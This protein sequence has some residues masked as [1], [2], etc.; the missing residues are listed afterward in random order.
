MVT[1]ILYEPKFGFGR[2]VPYT[3]MSHWLV[4]SVP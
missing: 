2:I 1:V 3:T 4:E